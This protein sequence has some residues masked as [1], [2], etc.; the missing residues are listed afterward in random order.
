MAP[1]LSGRAGV[2]A[3]GDQA[4]ARFPR[5]SATRRGASRIPLRRTGA[6]LHYQRWILP[7]WERLSESVR[8]A[9][10]DAG[11]RAAIELAPLHELAWSLADGRRTLAEIE[12]LVWLETGRKA[13][14]AFGRFFEWTTALELSRWV[15]NGRP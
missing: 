3:P 15:G 11:A 9:W 12:R 2:R 8:D 5:D 13:G 4:A 6:P 10:R 14:P 7:G 1:A